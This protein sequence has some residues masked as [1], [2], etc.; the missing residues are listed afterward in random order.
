MAARKTTKPAVKQ[1]APKSVA[2]RK[3]AVLRDVDEGSDEF[4]E[5]SYFSAGD[6]KTNIEF[7]ST[8][9]TILDEA[10]GGGVAEGRVL[11]VVGDSSTGKTL[12]AMEI[13]ANFALKHAEG[14]VRYA[15]A[16]LAFDDDYAEAMGMDLSRVER[17]SGSRLV[18]T[19]E[20]WHDDLVDFMKRLKGRP[21]L[22]ILDSLDAI[23]DDDEV[24]AEFGEASYGGKKPK[25][26][27]QLF[28]RTINDL[29][30]AN[31]T[32]MIVSQTRDKI[33]VT[34]GPTKTRSGGK[35]LEFYSSQIVWLAHVGKMDKTIDGIKRVIGHEVRAK[36]SKNKCGLAHRTVDY[37]VLYGY[38]IDDMMAGVTWLIENKCDEALEELELTKAGA[39]T[40]VAAMRNKPER[41]R[42][43]RPKMRKIVRREWARIENLFLPKARKY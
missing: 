29:H 39:K 16:E 8:G 10:L 15:E 6:S 14:L 25:L 23:S 37:P 40:S 28:R 12:L 18:G 4:V 9:C 11:N 22:Y 41:A 20:Q 24:K 13:A 7:I 5:P 34:F 35:A 26:I 19:V 30:A 2:A 3:R 33:G 27:S 32:L 21:G 42:E 31:V 38:G 1:A 17:N 43:F 36:V